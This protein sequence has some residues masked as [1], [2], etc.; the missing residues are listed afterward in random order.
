MVREMK[1]C[2][3]IV[4]LGRSITSNDFIISVSSTCEVNL[5]RRPESYLAEAVECSQPPTKLSSRVPRW[6]I[7]PLSLV[8]PRTFTTYCS[9]VL[10]SS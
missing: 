2:V 9:F 4:A 8:Q 10:A 3:G 7:I 5:S 6:P 1:C